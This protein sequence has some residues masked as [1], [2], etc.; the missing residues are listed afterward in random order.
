MVSEGLED[1]TVLF[2]DDVWSRKGQLDFLKAIFARNARFF[3]E[4]VCLFVLKKARRQIVNCV[5]LPLDGAAFNA[6]DYQL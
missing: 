1:E 5:V 2:L 3:P 4:N 6:I